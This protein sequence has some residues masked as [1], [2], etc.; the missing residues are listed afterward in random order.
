MSQLIKCT[1][2]ARHVRLSETS[3]PFCAAALDVGERAAAAQ[4][5]DARLPRR[6]IGRAALL[7]IGLGVIA[8]ATNACSS[9]DTSD[10]GTVDA[11]TDANIGV[12]YGAF[13]GDASFRDD[14]SVVA[15]YG[16]PFFPDASTAIDAATDGGP[17]ASDASEDGGDGGDAETR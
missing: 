14:G 10:E 3:C 4:A 8:P 17:D 15:A 1:S 6:R 9:D 7:A 2:C 5:I 11:G 12:L 16:A 13:M